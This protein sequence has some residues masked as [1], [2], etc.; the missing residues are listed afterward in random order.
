MQGGACSSCLYRRVRRKAK[1]NWLPHEQTIATDYDA[2]SSFLLPRNV[3]NHEPGLLKSTVSTDE[4]REKECASICVNTLLR[5]E[6]D[7][8]VFNTKFSSHT[9]LQS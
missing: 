2:Q 3:S 9:R 1:P 6:T 4:Q 5:Y 8:L 7:I